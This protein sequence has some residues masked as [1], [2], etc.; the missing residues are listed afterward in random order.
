M[1]IKKFFDVIDYFDEQKASYA[2]FMLDNETDHLFRMTRRL[3]ENKELIM[4]KSFREPFYRKYFPD[5]VRRQKV[6]EFIRLEQG[7]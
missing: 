7:I 3:L 6:R 2:T 5:S 4:W 1:K